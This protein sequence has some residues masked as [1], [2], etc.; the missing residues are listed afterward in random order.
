[1]LLKEC[2]ETSQ[3]SA[4]EKPIVEL[5]L[6]EPERIC[7]LSLKE[8]AKETYSS[9]SVCV[10]IAKKM[11]FSGWN[12]L[13]DAYMKEVNYLHT[14]FQNID[15]NIPFDARDKEMDIASK[16]ADLYQ[17]S[18]ADTL[19]LLDHDSLQ[20]AVRLLEKS[21]GI[22][23]FCISNLNYVAEE[24]A[25]KMK[26]INIPVY[27]NLTQGCIYHEA[28]MTPSDHCAICISYSGETPALLQTL[29]YLK[30]NHVPILAITSVGTNSLSK[31][32]DAILHISTREKMY[33]K[34]GGFS[35]LTSI[36]LILD[37]LYSCIFSIDYDKNMAYKT[38]IARLVEVN[39]RVDN[40]IIR[41]Y[42]KDQANGS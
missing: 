12:D 5:L 35:S 7:Q 22:H 32:A 4:G 10:R 19:S 9:P 25:F 38:D 42:K 18:V 17:E 3:F 16:I 39:R 41:E 29:R 28:A 13:K 24:F 20:K 11:G 30:S 27:Q 23:I 34:I 21:K 6:R 33:S 37:I 31:A 8:I 15:A 14:H 2:L 36:S 26:R 40:E 1:M